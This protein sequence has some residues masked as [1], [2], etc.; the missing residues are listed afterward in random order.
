MYRNHPVRSKGLDESLEVGDAG[1]SGAMEPI[2]RNV[3]LGEESREPPPR[4]QF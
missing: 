4:C 3:V 1:V 2:E